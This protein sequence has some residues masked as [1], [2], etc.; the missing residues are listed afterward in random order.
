MHPDPDRLAAI[1]ARL[2]GA[3]I[4]LDF[5]GTLAPIISDPSASRPVPGVIDTLAGLARAGAQIAVVTGRDAATVLELGDLRAIPDVVVSGLH[6]AE[7]WRHGDLQTRDEPAGL[8]ALRT[9]LPPLLRQSGDGVWLEDKRLS[10]VV[11]ARQA[12]DPQRVLTELGDRLP[13]LVAEQGLELHP[14][15][16]V[17]EIRIPNLSK[18]TAL[19]QLLI[20]STSAALFGGDDLGDLPALAAVSAWAALTGRPGLTIAVGELAELRQAADCAVGSPAELAVLLAQ[21]LATAETRGGGG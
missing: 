13:P 4:A 1:A 11:H 6:G 18:A 15:K 17:L 21:L 8:A 12:A 2:P 9:S 19:E 7:T 5:D 16:L 10:L 20:P 14:G 3:L